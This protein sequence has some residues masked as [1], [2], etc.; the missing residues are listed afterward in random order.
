MP[1]LT[2]LLFTILL[3]DSNDN[4]RLLLEVETEQEK[5]YFQSLSEAMEVGIGSQ[6]LYILLNNVFIG[7]IIWSAVA[8]IHLLIYERNSNKTQVLEKRTFTLA[9]AICLIFFLKEGMRIGITILDLYNSLNLPYFVTLATLVMPHAIFEFMG[10]IMMAI[11]A[12]Y[13]LKEQLERKEGGLTPPKAL[14]VILPIVLIGVSAV[15]ETTVTPMIFSNY[16]ASVL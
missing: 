9:Y 7:L 3:P 12:L 15:L 1:Q 5:L 2:F 6:T 11:F 14:A 13:W 16:I 4:T 10:F 8:V